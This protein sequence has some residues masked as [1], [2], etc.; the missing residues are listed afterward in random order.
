M[1]PDEIAAGRRRWQE[2]YAAA[3]TRDA[4]F[5]TLSGAEVETVYGPR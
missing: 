1:T 3:R 4:A 5:T 2:R